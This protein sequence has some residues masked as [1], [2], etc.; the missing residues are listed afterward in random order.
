M[1]SLPLALLLGCIL[2][3]GVISA[4]EPGKLPEGIHQFNGMLVGRLVSKDVERGTFVVAVDAVPRVWRNSK[5]E[6]PKSVVG[7]TVEVDGVFGKWLDVL[8]VMKAGETLEFECKHNRGDRLTFPG[9]LL[10]KV[11]PYDPSDYPELPEEF[12]GFA[13]AVTAK[14]IKKDP[15]T[16]EAIIKVERVIEPWENNKSKDTQAIVGK[17]LMLAG[18]WQRKDDYHK[19]KVGDR[20]DVGMRHIGMRSEHLTVA[21]FIRKAKPKD[22]EESTSDKP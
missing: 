3:C 13:G 12:R 8:L 2:T 22:A 1:K 7:K 19:L 10:R 14:V 16:L 5:A 4:A 15:E 21:E 11:A 20:I 18:F 17:P 6:N 9:E